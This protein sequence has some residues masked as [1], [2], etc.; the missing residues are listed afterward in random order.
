MRTN[1]IIKKK[2]LSLERKKRIVGFAF[3]SPFILGTLVFFLYPIAYSIFISFQ[4]FTAGGSI[5]DMKFNGLG[6]YLYAFTVDTQFLP[7][8]IQV[9]R[10]TLINSPLIVVFALILAI[11]LNKKFAGR[12]LFRTILILPF[13]LGTGLIFRYLLYSGET[14]EVLKIARGIAMPHE[15]V[16]YLG[17]D[18]A[19][20]I[21]LFLNQMT[22]VFWKSGLQILLFLSGLQNISPSLYESAKCDAATEWEML[23]Y[24]TTPMLTPIII[25]NFIYTIIDSFADSNNAIMQYFNLQAFEFVKFDYAS[26]ISWIYFTTVFI[27]IG[28]VYA[29]LHRFSTTNTETKPISTRRKEQIL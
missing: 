26:A 14:E 8:F 17:E 27:F 29:I 1:I 16:V 10:D 25:I 28:I 7:K 24:I 20:I 18:V 9:L 3:V 15:F 4:S 6:H 2:H 21:S 23:W 22:V 11:C 19:K 13:L 5:R 12:S